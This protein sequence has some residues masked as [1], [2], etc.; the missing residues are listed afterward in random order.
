[1]ALVHE[2]DDGR[3]AREGIEDPVAEGRRAVPYADDEA[4]GGHAVEDGFHGRAHGL[5]AR[6]VD[7]PEDAPVRE[8][9]D[10]GPLARIDPDH[11]LARRDDAF[12][13]ARRLL[14]RG[15][16]VG[17]DD[18]GGMVDAG[19]LCGRGDQRAHVRRHRIAGRD[20][21]E[22]QASRAQGVDEVVRGGKVVGLDAEDL[23]GSG[24]LTVATL[25]PRGP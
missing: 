2:L 1:M 11:A 24:A 21:H 5:G 12:E 25:A 19:Q 3:Q 9:G 17:V 7:E 16:D 22:R 6:G 13:D 18:D 23:Q 4:L 15:L 8:H 10:A 14:E 20:G